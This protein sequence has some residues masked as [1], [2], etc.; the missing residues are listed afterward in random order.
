MPPSLQIG[1]LVLGGILLLIGI[2]GGN[3]KLF[4]YEGPPM[5][6]HFLRFISFVIGTVLIVA[7]LRSGAVTTPPVKPESPT[8]PESPITPPVKP[9]SPTAPTKGCILTINANN[10]PLMS[11]PDLKSQQIALL[12]SGSYASL[13]YRS[14]NSYGMFTEGWFQI[15]LKGRRGWIQDNTWTISNKSRECS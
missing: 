4:G 3:F 8:A 7:A 5:S 11:E 6:N 1:L 15:E 9:E 12:M 13:S 14:I 2:L 10:I